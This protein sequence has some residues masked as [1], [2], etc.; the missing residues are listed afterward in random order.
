VVL[1]GDLNAD[2]DHAALRSLLETGLRDAHD[3]R[4]RGLARTWPAGLPVLHLDHV[5]VRDGAGARVVVRSVREVDLPGSDHLGV[6][7]ELAV[8]PAQPRSSQR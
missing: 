7:A 5:L 1:A 6:V 3:E 4:G 2:R 8:L